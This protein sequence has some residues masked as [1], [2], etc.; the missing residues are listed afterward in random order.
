MPV[1]TTAEFDLVTIR[2]TQ[3]RANFFGTLGVPNIE[4]IFSADVPQAFLAKI[5]I[6]AERYLPLRVDNHLNFRT[7]A[8]LL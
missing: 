8:S 2:F 5:V 7:S 6:A 1:T 3:M 4:Y